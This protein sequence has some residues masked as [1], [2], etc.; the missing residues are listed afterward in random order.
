MIKNEIKNLTELCQQEAHPHIV[1]VLRIGEISNTHYLFIDM[2]LCD[3]NLDEYI[4][5]TK[6]QEV[7]PTVF[8]KDQPPPMRARQIWTVM[9]QIVKGVEYLHQKKMIHR[10]LKPANSYIYLR[11][12]S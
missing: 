10:D 12:I 5:C 11:N 2:E 1:N 4:Y 6:P 7:A 3:L 9:L 8:I